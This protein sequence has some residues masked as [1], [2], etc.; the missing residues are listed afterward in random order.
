MET[1]LSSSLLVGAL[2]R[3]CE[4]GGGFAAVL[5]KGDPDAGAILVIL[6]ERGRKLRIMERT[7]G[8]QG[9]YAWQDV[10]EQAAENE[11]E[12]GKFLSRRRT[13]DPDLWIIE[14][15]IAS[16]ERFAAEMN[17]AV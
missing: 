15:D 10:V 3:K 7:L 8:P 14:L 13:Y 5:A 11:D 4:S 17:E 12:I 1:R 16:A 6:A 9:R 2:K